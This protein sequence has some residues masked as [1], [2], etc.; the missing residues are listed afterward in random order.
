MSSRWC[1]LEGIDNELESLNHK[2]N[3]RRAITTFVTN[4]SQKLCET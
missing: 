3:G 1:K 4:I 2:I